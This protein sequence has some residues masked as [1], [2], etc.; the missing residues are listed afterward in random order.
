MTKNIIFKE[1]KWTPLMSDESHLSTLDDAIIQEIIDVIGVKRLES[2]DIDM[3][4]AVQ[5][6]AKVYW[7]PVK[8]FKKLVKRC[9]FDD[10]DE[11]LLICTI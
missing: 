3:I 10:L 9:S 1:M 11:L 8:D 6:E 4:F 5:Y 2:L 7:M